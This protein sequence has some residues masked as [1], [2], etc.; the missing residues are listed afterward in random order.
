[1]NKYIIKKYSKIPKLATII[2]QVYYDEIEATLKP[3][4]YKIFLKN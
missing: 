2:Q 3:S 1:M 4:R